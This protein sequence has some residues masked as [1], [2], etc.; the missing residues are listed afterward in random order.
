M[1]YHFGFDTREVLRICTGGTPVCFSRILVVLA[2]IIPI[3]NKQ[4]ASDPRL[5]YRNFTGLQHTWLSVP[6]PFLCYHLASCSQH[7]QNFL[8]AMLSELMCCL[9]RSSPTHPAGA[10]AVSGALAGTCHHCPLVRASGGFVKTQDKKLTNL[11]LAVVFKFNYAFY[12]DGTTLLCDKKECL[13]CTWKTNLCLC[14]GLILFTS[15]K[16][17]KNQSHA[18]EIYFSSSGNQLNSTF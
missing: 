6:L 9:Q 4:P 5:E 17:K 8:S 1:L 12:G 2:F 7:Q 10:L 13:L 18:V 16:A 15:N 11:Q 14:L 3:S